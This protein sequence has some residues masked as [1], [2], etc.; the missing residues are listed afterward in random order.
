M[1]KDVSN[2]NEFLEKNAGTINQCPNDLLGE[3]L[4]ER[5]KVLCGFCKKEMDIWDSKDLTCNHYFCDSCWTKQIRANIIEGKLWSEFE[6]LQNKCL[7]L[8]NFDFFKS[9]KLDQDV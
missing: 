6:C 1:A 4:G 9:L 5:T 2:V 8:M 7:K 3:S